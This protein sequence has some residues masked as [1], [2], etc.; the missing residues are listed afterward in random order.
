MVAFASIA[1]VQ[2]GVLPAKDEPHHHLSYQ[3]SSIRVLRV[4]VAPKDTTYL[5]QHDADY[6]WISIGNSDIVNAKVGSKDA[7]VRTPNLAVHFSPGPFAHVARNRASTPFDNIT[8]EFLKKQ[9]GARN[10][11]EA[12]VNEEKGDCPTALKHSGVSTKPLFETDQVAVALVTLAP[13]ALTM[14]GRQWIIAVDTSQTRRALSLEGTGTWAHGVFH[15][16][17][18]GWQLKN[19]GSSTA[20]VLILTPKGKF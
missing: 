3:D 9:T 10:Q 7:I 1:A 11:C 12:A 17:T 5:H 20:R 19:R 6:M 15:S 4:H 16:A 18:G 13:N 2:S 14:G 8:V